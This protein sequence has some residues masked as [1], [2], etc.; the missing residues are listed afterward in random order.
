MKQFMEQCG[1]KGF[2][3]EHMAMMK[4]FCAGKDIPDVEKMKVMMEKCGCHIPDSKVSQ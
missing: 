1:K 4:A 2:T 3:E